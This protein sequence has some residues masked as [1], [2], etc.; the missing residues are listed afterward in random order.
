M[1][2]IKI[3][4]KHKNLLT[5]VYVDYGHHKEDIIQLMKEEVQR[6]F[7]NQYD[8]YDVREF[9]ISDIPL[10]DPVVHYSPSE[11]ELKNIE[12]F[13][14]PEEYGVLF[15][16]KRK[17]IEEELPESFAII[18]IC[19]DG[20]RFYEKLFKNYNSLHILVVQDY[21]FGGNYNSFGVDGS[22]YK[23]AKR[24]NVLP[25]YILC[26]ANSRIWEGYYE[27]ISYTKL[28]PHYQERSLY[29]LE[30]LYLDD[31]SNEE[32]YDVIYG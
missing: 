28:E 19:C 16:F 3:F 31:A 11:E 17:Y 10:K 14:V 21:G 27:I 26:A 9:E 25:K 30:D 2:P 29:M 7:M 22:M 32:M 4:N 1:H 8:I 5:Y 24:I 12:E 13:S 23:I 15:V 6:Q 20:I 18:Y